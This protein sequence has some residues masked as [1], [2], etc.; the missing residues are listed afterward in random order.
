MGI[1]VRKRVVEEDEEE[2]IEEQKRKSRPMF[3]TYPGG[4]EDKDL[5]ALLSQVAKPKVKEEEV[6][7]KRDPE[8]V[9]GETVA[10][11]ETVVQIKPDPEATADVK[12]EPVPNEVPAAVDVP[13]KQEEGQPAGG[14]VFKKRKAK[15]IRQK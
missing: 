6:E 7:V 12:A 13:V 8:A 4:E 2:K 9:V 15:N 14:V 5:D 10:A 3:R 11:T 1:G